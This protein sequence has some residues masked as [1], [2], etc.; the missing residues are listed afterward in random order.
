MRYLYLPFCHVFPS[1]DRLHRQLAPL[2]AR[3]DQSFVWLDHMKA[4][5][6]A[7]VKYMEGI[8]DAKRRRHAYALSMRP[9]P[10]SG[11]ILADLWARHMRPWNDLSVNRAT[12]LSAEERALALEEI[13]Q[14][15]SN[16]SGV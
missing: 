9:V 13:R 1:N 16:N 7:Q 12:S 4:G 5:I 14:M 10:I 2:L 3:D 8:D 6:A 15:Q 11:N